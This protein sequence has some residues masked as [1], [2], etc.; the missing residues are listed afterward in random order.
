[1]D[2]KISIITPSYNQ[3]RFIEDSIISVM[4]QGYKNYE[5]IIIDGVSKDNTIEILN[6]YK[7]I[8]WI[9]EKDTG[10][11]D[12]LKKALKLTTG[13]IIGWLNADDYYYE[14]IFSEINDIFIDDETDAIYANLDYVNKNK[15]KIK[16]RVSKSKYIISNK[17]VSKFICFIPSTTFFFKKKILDEGITFDTDI[18][19]GM[20]KDLFAQIY[21]KNFNIRKLEKNFALFRLHENNKFEYKKGLKYV[22]ID[23]NEGILIYNK[24]STIKIPKNF[25]GLFVYAFIRFILKC[26]G[27]IMFNLFNRTK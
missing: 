13:E 23:L 19:Y 8:K 11:T 21:H 25:F 2:K 22:M 7:H 4:N 9:S 6:K 5:H 24:Y 10:Q 26:L 16:H 15:E 20:D 12:A 17:F 3:G 18:N 14:N 27:F 1:M